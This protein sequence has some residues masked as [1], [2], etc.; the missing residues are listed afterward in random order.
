MNLQASSTQTYVYIA[1]YYR[2][3]RKSSRKN[4]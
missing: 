3:M 2:N 4:K 1:I